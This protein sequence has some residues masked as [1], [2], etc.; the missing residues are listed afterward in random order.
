MPVKTV[1]ACLVNSFFKLF[2][3]DTMASSP[4]GLAGQCACG[5][6]LNL[7]KEN[8]LHEWPGDRG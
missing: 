7:R 3:T 2:L 6:Y 8:F 5:I 4:G 1:Q